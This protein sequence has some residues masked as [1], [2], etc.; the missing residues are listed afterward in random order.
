MHSLLVFSKDQQKQQGMDIGFDTQTEPK[1]AQDSD[2]Q[3]TS[4]M[5]FHVGTN[6]VH[7]TF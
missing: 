1:S 7:T 4:R 6:I 2:L 5:K 3:V